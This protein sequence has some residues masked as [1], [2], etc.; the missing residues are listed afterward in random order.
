MLTE[1]QKRA[2][3]AIVNIFETSRPL[4]DYSKVTLLQGDSGHLTYGRSQTT[5]SSGNL[6]LLIKRYCE[7]AGAELAEALTPYLGRLEYRDVN[8]DQDMKFRRLLRDAGRDPVMQSA[9]DRF[10]DSVYW[11]PATRAARAIAVEQA[12]GVGVVYDSCIH[13]S[14]S[15]MRGRTEER[16]GKVADI[17]EKK[18][19][20]DYIEVRR[21]WL[22]HHSNDLLHKTVYRMNS[23]RELIEEGN[24]DLDL[25]FTCRG[26]LVSESVLTEPG[27]PRASSEADEMRLLR[28]QTPFLRGEDVRELQEA[29]AKAGL[30]LTV[31]GIFGPATDNAVRK[32]QKQHDLLVDGIVGPAT[33]ATLDL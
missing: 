10:F 2:A 15:L 16:F 29:L 32:W 22:A 28:L 13:G 6:Y 3:Q 33:R 4:G 5:L 30:T 9:Q 1:L 23:F 31:D 11:K 17:G 21:D 19:I 7:S 27:D 24:W 26:V 14:W 12:L 20:Q 18:W 8:L 25:P